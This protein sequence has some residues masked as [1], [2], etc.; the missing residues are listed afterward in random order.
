[1]GILGSV[2]GQP[3]RYFWVAGVGGKGELF[4]TP[5]KLYHISN[6]TR[7]ASGENKQ[8]LTKYIC[9]YVLSRHMHVIY[10]IAQNS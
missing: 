9:V 8:K 5:Q 6:R 4:L 2:V 7:P 1:M 10:K 3:K